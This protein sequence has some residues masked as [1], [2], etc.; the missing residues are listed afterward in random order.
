MGATA[1]WKVGATAMSYL[2]SSCSSSTLPSSVAP[3]PP[4]S[5]SSSS[6]GASS[7]AAGAPTSLTTRSSVFCLF[8]IPYS[9]NTWVICT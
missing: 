9:G 2:S 4:F 8:H 7:G 5:Y 6:T 1:Q 3:T